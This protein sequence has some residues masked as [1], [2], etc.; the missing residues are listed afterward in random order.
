MEGKEEP[1]E[2]R[3]IIPQAFDHIFTEIAK[4]MV[5]AVT[6]FTALLTTHLFGGATSA[7]AFL[8]LYIVSLM[9]WSHLC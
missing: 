4:G 5:P 3:G 9:W 7:D 1:P 6:T 2:L 8:Q